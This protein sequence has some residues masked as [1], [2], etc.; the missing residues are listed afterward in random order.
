MLKY[1]LKNR[2]L[3]SIV[4]VVA[5]NLITIFVFDKPYLETC[6]EN[7]LLTSIYEK[8]DIDYDI[9]APTKD[10]LE[11]IK[12]LDFIDDVFGY[13]YTESTVKIGNN[14]TKTKIL[15]SD[16]MPSLEFTMYNDS[17][18]IESMDNLDNPIYVDYEFSK[19]NNISLGGEIT[20]NNIKFQVSR[21]YETNTY[22]NSAILAPLVGEQKKLIESNSK[23]YSGAYLKC[24]DLSKAETY[25]KDYKPQGRLKNRSDFSSDEEYQTHYNSWNNANYYNEITS[26]AAKESSI[27]KKTS[28]SYVLGNIISVIV[29]I[30]LFVLLSF[31]NSEKNYF[32]SKKDKAGIS[33]YYIVAAIID[34]ILIIVGMVASVFISKNMVA[35]YLTTDFMTP[36]FVASII[37]GCLVLI[38][39]V[40]Y[41]IIFKKKI[42][43]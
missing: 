32:S 40:I 24:N 20:F 25:L 11:E 9:P 14:S 26:F 19:K 31:R 39:D 15:L 27:N 37:S 42:I 23:S 17:R 5:L 4:A 6:S 41:S 30:G 28:I 22:Y 13:Y 16:M 18:L 43:R 34:F 38:I 2:F 8:T 36:M 3:F 29:M 35:N 33:S 7:L 21:I 1:W 12:N 10:Q